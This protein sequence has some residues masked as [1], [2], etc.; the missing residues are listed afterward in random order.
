MQKDVVS[1]NSKD[2][3][4]CTS[5]LDIPVPALSTG[6]RQLSLMNTGGVY[7]AV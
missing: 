3:E 1:R 7:E 6:C 5:K 2:A 4:E